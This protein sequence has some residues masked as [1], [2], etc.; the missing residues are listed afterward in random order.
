VTF[1]KG[2]TVLEK[3]RAKYPELTSYI[4]EIVPGER[5]PNQA[6]NHR[7]P[8]CHTLREYLRR[9]RYRLREER[10]ARCEAGRILRRGDDA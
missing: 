5:R 2:T 10:A 1:E 7:S 3:Y 4:R 8:D 9:P 6:E